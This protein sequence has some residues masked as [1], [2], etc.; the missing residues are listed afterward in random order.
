MYFGISMNNRTR[1]LTNLLPFLVR[2]KLRHD[3]DYVHDRFTDIALEEGKLKQIR[4]IRN[5][6]DLIF[7]EPVLKGH[8][9]ASLRNMRRVI[10]M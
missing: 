4:E 10:A 5:E 7:L 2:D 1:E 6:I 9:G 3:L 8:L